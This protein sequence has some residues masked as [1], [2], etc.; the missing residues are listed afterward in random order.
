MKTNFRKMFFAV[1]LLVTGAPA[2]MTGLLTS[3]DF[4]SNTPLI[5]AA[6]AD[7]Y[8]GPLCQGSSGAYCCKDSDGSC[9]AGAKCSGC[10]SGNEEEIN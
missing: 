5:T 4:S 8:K 3:S 9:S 2:L 1:A 7:T 6:Y 10:K